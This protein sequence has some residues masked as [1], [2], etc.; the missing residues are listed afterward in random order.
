MNSCKQVDVL[1]TDFSKAFD[2]VN[3]T[4][5]IRKLATFGIAANLLNW[6]ESYLSNRRQF[7]KL[8]TAESC[9]FT[10]HS[11]V[12]Q[13]SHIGPLLF[14]M[15]INDLPSIATSDILISMFADDVRIAKTINNLSDIRTLQSTID[16][17]RD[18]CILND[19]H[20]NLDKCAVLTL[21][22]SRSR[23]Q[24]TYTF[25]NHTFIHT[26]EQR[27]LGV[28]I[29]NRLS[30]ND[31]VE[32]IIS[33]STAALGFVKRFCRNLNDGATTKVV[34]SALVQSHLDYC[35]NVWLTIPSTKADNIESVLRQ[36]TMFA[37]KQYPN[38]SNN[39][40][41]DSYVTRLESLKMISLERRRINSALIFFFDLLNNNIN[42]PFV[43]DLVH[44]NINAHNFRNPELF[45]IVN[46]ILARNPSVP[47][48]RTL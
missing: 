22:K 16:K 5:L 47:L 44:V 29:D 23:L 11:G 9:D 2:K 14:L 48:T 34:Y 12:P 19:L 13:G 43:R 31:H 28:L 26:D 24:S 15:F 37:L 3:H 21:H 7:V 8:G 10:V 36:F 46:T 6:I 1:H 25:G 27:D 17:L 39:Y 30:F 45:K 40:H 18:W 38:I 20:L 35:S 4:V 42:C 33:K 32:W 41:I